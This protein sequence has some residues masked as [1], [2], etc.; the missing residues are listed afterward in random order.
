VPPLPASLP[1]PPPR[2]FAYNAFDEALTSGR[3]L[4]RLTATEED[5][6]L[7]DSWHRS[8]FG[9]AEDS[10][11]MHL[12]KHGGRRTD[13]EYTLDAR[14]FFLE[15]R[16]RAVPAELADGSQGLKIKFK[17]LVDGK[18]RSVG[19]YWTPE[20]QAVTFFD[21]RSYGN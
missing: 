2:V 12:N 19:G 20:G 16:E 9:S 18:K 13:L 7:R 15:H 3:G 10:L 1:V 11:A 6:F 17:M 8:T 21:G 14:R 4:P 5:L